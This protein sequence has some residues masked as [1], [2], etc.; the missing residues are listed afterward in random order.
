VSELSTTVQPCPNLTVG[1]LD[2]DGDDELVFCNYCYDSEIWIYRGGADFQVD[3]PTVI[4][5]EA[6][7]VRSGA[8]LYPVVADMDGDGHEDLVIGGY[9][10]SGP[11][12]K[13]WFGRDG[14]PWNWSTPD[15]VI[16]LT[17]DVGL[18]TRLALGDYDGDRI[19]DLAGTVYSQPDPG[20]YVY[21]TRS[22]KSVRSRSFSLDDADRVL[23]T[24]TYRTWGNIG[25]LN[26]HRRRYEMLGVINPGFDRFDPSQ[27]IVF[28]GGP[29]GPDSTYE[30]RYRTSEDGLVDGKTFQNISPLLDCNGDGWDDLLVS[31]PSWWG[32][33]Q[34]IAIVL[35]GG[36]MIPQ[37][38]PPSAVNVVASQDNADALKLWPVPT[39]DRLNILW[40]GDLRRM[41]A[42]F[43]IHD[44]I[45]RRVAGGTV[46]PGRGAALWNCAD[47]PP[48]TYLLSVFDESGEQ[49]ATASVV[50]TS[51]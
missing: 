20:I 2:N 22:G 34:G 43:E 51:S 4:I 14:S 50:K 21:L 3:T 1:D 7:G 46:D 18:N 48:G 28:S 49:I 19:P 15:R 5:T 31:D 42:R 29:A 8:T 30:A 26:D 45:G 16:D 25:F 17:T 38:F 37:D 40:R 11:K 27:L 33:D 24:S 41:P 6:E 13:I 32:Y 47:V 44:A 35:S 36:P 9:Y 39:H 23:K 12:L 10:A